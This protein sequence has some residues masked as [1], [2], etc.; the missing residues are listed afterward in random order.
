[1]RL[2]LFSVTCLVFGLHSMAAQAQM[3][4]PMT[5]VQL[6]DMCASR[7]DVEAGLCA[8]Y[9]TAVAE[10]L[11]SESDPVRRICL[12]PAIAPQTLVDNVRAVWSKYPPQPQD[13]AAESV[14]VAL[15]QQFDCM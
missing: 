7:Y 1:M 6:Q 4:T 12:S 2:L 5:A 15:R 13:F 8:G 10:R 3:Q 11:L 9:V 14:E